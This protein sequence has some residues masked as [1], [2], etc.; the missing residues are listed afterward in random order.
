MC[1]YACVYTCVP[2]C[3]CISLCVYVCTCACSYISVC[4]YKDEMSMNHDSVLQ[5]TF[6]RSLGCYNW[7][8][9]ITV[10]GVERTL[11]NT[12]NVHKHQYKEEFSEAE[13][14][15]VPKL[16]D[17]DPREGTDNGHQESTNNR[18]I[19]LHPFIFP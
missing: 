6:S 2:M 19:G 13:V 5:E 4:V 1:V 14:S 3:L 8:E 12:N 10:W 7:K 16:C 11:V 18:K 15:I 9:D 17:S